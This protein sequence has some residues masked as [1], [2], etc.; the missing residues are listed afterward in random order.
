MISGHDVRFEKSGALGIRR[1]VCM[2]AGV[3][4]ARKWLVRSDIE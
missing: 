2:A 4:L 1:R 3:V